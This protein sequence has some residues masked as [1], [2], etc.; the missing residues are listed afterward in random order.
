MAMLDVAQDLT[1]HPN[2]RRYLSEMRRQYPHPYHP[3][4]G[5]WRS[6]RVIKTKK[7]GELF[8][9]VIHLGK[10]DLA[11]S[12][13]FWAVLQQMRKRIQPRSPEDI[14]SEAQ[15]VDML[16]GAN[17]MVFQDRPWSLVLPPETAVL[18]PEPVVLTSGQYKSN[19][20]D[21]ILG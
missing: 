4:D 16:A 14:H 20:L 8:E 2:S 21:Q 18:A 19:F 3:N 5:S 13:P 11:V 10:L 6:E 17:P 15:V 7:N 9:Q 1:S 12:Y